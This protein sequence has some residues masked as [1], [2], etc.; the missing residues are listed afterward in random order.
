MKLA[1]LLT[2]ALMILSG[3]TSFAREKQASNLTVRA[4]AYRAIP[5][6]RTSYFQTQGQSNTSC[7][8]SSSDFGMWTNL[9]LNCNT[10]STPPTVQPVTIRSI[11]VFNF[12]EAN[13]MGYTITCTGHWVGIA[14]SWLT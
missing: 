10:V 1:T 3:R 14:S 11:E 9:N 5:H 4:V 6:E 13:G 7:Y 12:V 2:T 8:G